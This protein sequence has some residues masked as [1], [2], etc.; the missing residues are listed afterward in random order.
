MKRSHLG[1]VFVP[2]APLLLL[3]L[4]PCCTPL[5]L[6]LTSAAAAHLRCCCTPLLLT[7]LL[8]S[9]SALLLQ[10]AFWQGIFTGASVHELAG[11]VA[12]GNAMGP[13]VAPTA[14]VTKLVRV[15]MLAP[16]LLIMNAIPSLRMRGS[17]SGATTSA[18]S[19]SR[20]A[21]AS[22]PIPWFALG[23]VLVACVN[24]VV[25]FDKALLKL[26]AKAS[27]TALAMAMAALGLDTDLD[28]IRKLGPRPLVLAAALWAWLLLGVGGVARV[29]VGVLLP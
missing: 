22:P 1:L 27:A 13:S 26:V 12:A 14:I 15:C 5:P 11:V 10:S 7:L 25:T 29:L 9:A 8:T 23:F 6:L 21:G 24:S 3:N 17:G 20:A 28:K 18:S 19:T 16:C 2:A 4:C